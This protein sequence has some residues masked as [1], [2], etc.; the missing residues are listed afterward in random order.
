MPEFEARLQRATGY[1][2]DSFERIS[3]ESKEEWE[4]AWSAPG[5]DFRITQPEFYLY[6]SMEVWANDE[7]WAVLDKLC[8][9]GTSYI[10]PRPSALASFYSTQR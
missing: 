5:R 8:N 9:V 7:Y 3:F 10:L 4:R 2:L 6:M 1:K